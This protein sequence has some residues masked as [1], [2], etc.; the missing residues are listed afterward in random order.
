MK[1]EYSYQKKGGISDESNDVAKTSH[2]EL[3]L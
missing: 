1:T 3:V 2:A